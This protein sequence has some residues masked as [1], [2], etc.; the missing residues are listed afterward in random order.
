MKEIKI[1]SCNDC[2]FIDMN[3]MSGGYNC[4]LIGMFIPEDKRTFQPIFNKEKC[5]IVKEDY[6]FVYDK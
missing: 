5:P 3:D 6:N 4:K 2:P 1:K